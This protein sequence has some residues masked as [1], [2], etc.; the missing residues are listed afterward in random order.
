[1]GQSA[2]GNG[3]EEIGGGVPRRS[4]GGG[5]SADPAV[6]SARYALPQRVKNPGTGFDFDD[7]VGTTEGRSADEDSPGIGASTFGAPGA[8]AE[9]AFA[10][11]VV[12]DSFDEVAPPVT[13]L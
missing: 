7:S 3:G 9:L 13:A 4:G 1:M 8:L 6:Q 10:S 12:A 5:S 11:A 2:P